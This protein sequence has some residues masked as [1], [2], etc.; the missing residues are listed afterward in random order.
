MI[1]AKNYSNTKNLHLGHWS[2]P[3]YSGIS[4]T[5]PE[6]GT[7]YKNRVNRLQKCE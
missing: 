5:I 1:G 3:E 7:K 4:F 6:M 2:I